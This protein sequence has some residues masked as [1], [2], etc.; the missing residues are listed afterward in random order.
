MSQLSES[1]AEYLKLRRALGFKL[2]DVGTL[3]QQ[4][5]DF[6]EKQGTMFVTRDAALRW[7]TAPKGCNPARWAERLGAVRRFALY[8]SAI[9]PRTE[10]PPLGLLPHHY[11][12]R[13]PYLYSRRDIQQLVESANRLCS[14]LGLRAATYSTIFGLVAVT[15]MRLSEPMALNR[16]DVDLT[17]GILVVRKTK[18]GKS[19][20]VPVH[21]STRDVLRRYAALRDRVFPT[22][23]TPSFFLTERGTRPN[24]YSVAQ[25][26]K[27]LTHQ[28][29][30]RSQTGRSPRFHDLRHGFAIRALLHLYRTG[31]E[32]EPHLAALATYLG[33]VDVVSTYWYLTATP[34]L[35]RSASARL[36]GKKRE[37]NP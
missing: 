35:L 14:P 33:H 3:L 17:E 27:Q 28:L 31:Q 21:T 16:D 11:R 2:N 6:A 36:N 19:R 13:D 5:A 10:I 24:K 22:P 12:R 25:T 4:F 23:T 1:V 15:G 29:G 26:F 9:D 20:L 34:D 18:F 7:A 30:L 37:A 8:Q 32:V